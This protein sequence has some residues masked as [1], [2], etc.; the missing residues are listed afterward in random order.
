MKIYSSYD[1]PNYSLSDPASRESRRV[2]SG[3]FSLRQAQATIVCVSRITLLLSTFFSLFF[4]LFLVTKSYAQTVTP[5]ETPTPTPTPTSASASQNSRVNDLQN[6]IKDLQNKVSELQG[7]SKTLS[8][9]IGVMDN[10]IKLTQLKI[11][12]TEQ[13]I[14]D[15]TE[16]INTTNKKIG[17]LENALSNLTKVLVKRIVVTYQVGSIE[18]LSVLAKSG[19]M[20]EF[21]TKVNYLGIAQAHDKE[22]LVETQ[23]AKNDYANQKAI[24]E[25]KK[26]KVEALKAQLDEYTKQLDADKKN[27]EALLKITQNNEQI[28]QQK[29][30]AALAEQKAIQQIVSGGGT[31]VLVGPVKEGGLVGQVIVGKS[32]CSSGTHL[33]FE[34]HKNDSLQDPTS[35]LNNKSVNFENSPDSSFSFSGPWI[36]PLT[37]PIYISQGFGMTYWAR[38]GWYGGGPHTGIDMYSKPS[39]EVRAVKEGS[40]YRGSIACGGGQLLF[41]RVDQADG[42][43]AFYL[44]IIP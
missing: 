28:Y 8:S 43:Q 4:S 5:T 21:L 37:D 39:L 12:S 31:A 34:V 9:Q 27:K 24:F 42:V 7:Q 13:E 29:L 10:Q 2:Q 11:R 22:L 14:A 25:D 1:V 33:H 19:G 6:E 30:A 35:F 15:I 3:K 18:P 40:L 17:S 26:K 44:H 36:W 41:A 23:Q 38:I 32:P 16:D 20:A